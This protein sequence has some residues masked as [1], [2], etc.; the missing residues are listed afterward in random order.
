MILGCGIVTTDL[1]TV[2]VRSSTTLPTFA[3]ST[4]VQI[5]NFP[6][7]RIVKTGQESEA[8]VEDF[9]FPPA[10]DK[11]VR[12]L[13]LVSVPFDSALVWCSQRRTCRTAYRPEPREWL[14][15]KLST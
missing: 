1:I 3:A 5:Q 15:V 8:F 4:S 9:Q 12:D 10:I 2:I 6:V 14:G 7:R 11:A 13:D